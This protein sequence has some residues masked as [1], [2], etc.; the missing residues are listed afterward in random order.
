MPEEGKCSECGENETLRGEVI[1]PN[2]KTG[3]FVFVRYYTC[4]VCLEPS[5]YFG[6]YDSQKVE[7]TG[8]DEPSG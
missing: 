3:G 5:L 6:Q 7:V 2:A 1:W 4:D 8:N